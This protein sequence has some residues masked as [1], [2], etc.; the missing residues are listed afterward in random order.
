MNKEND[1]DAIFEEQRS[2][3][4]QDGK[5]RLEIQQKIYDLKEQ[6]RLKRELDSYY[7]GLD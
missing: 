6:Q 2:Q 1:K 5:K 3:H 7:D 4:K